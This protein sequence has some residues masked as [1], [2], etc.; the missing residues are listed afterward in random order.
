MVK[1]GQTHRRR[2]AGEA[3]DGGELRKSATGDQFDHGLVL[4]VAGARAHLVGQVGGAGVERA[5]RS[6][7]RGSGRSSVVGDFAAAAS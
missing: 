2:D 4:R 5:R 7:A 6:R 1:V 3:R